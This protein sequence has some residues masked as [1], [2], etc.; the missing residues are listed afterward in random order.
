MLTRIFPTVKFPA[1]VITFSGFSG[2]GPFMGCLGVCLAHHCKSCEMHIPASRLS[3]RF[4]KR[5]KIQ[6]VE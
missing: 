2:L 1:Y 4:R 6:G 5:H 3:G